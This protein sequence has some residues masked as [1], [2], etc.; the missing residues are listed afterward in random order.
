MS[1]SHGIAAA[2]LDA[3]IRAGQLC[4]MLNG[5]KSALFGMLAGRG[6]EV[7]MIPFQSIMLHVYYCQLVHKAFAI[8]SPFFVFSKSIIHRP[9]VDSLPPT[10]IH[11]VVTAQ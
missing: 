7:V 5:Q 9:S 1:A 3:T 11:A 8:T 6:V 10:V 2:H 4:G